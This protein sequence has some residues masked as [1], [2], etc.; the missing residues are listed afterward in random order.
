MKKMKLN[1]GHNGQLQDVDTTCEKCVLRKKA[2][3]PYLE[4]MLNCRLFKYSEGRHECSPE[5][6]HFNAEN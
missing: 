6:K 4:E 2:T 1:K 3:C 5:K